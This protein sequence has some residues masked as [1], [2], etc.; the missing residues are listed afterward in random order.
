MNVTDVTVPVCY[1]HF[2]SFLSWTGRGGGLDV[3]VWVFLKGHALIHTRK[4]E[5]HDFCRKTILK[6]PGPP[7]ARDIWSRGTHL[8]LT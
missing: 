5:G 3:F 2:R 6:Y 8:S 1:F 7:P 4:W